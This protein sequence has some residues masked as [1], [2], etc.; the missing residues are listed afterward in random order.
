MRLPWQ[1]HLIGLIVVISTISAETAYLFF[2]V[3]S[4][5]PEGLAGRI[6][7]TLDAALILVLTY[8]FATSISQSRASQRASDAP[9][10]PRPPEPLKGP[11]P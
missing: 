5:I 3:K 2:G 10:L 9:V 7:G 8:Y 1:L 4:A 11:T 6:L